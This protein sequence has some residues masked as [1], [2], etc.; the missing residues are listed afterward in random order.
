ML[1]RKVWLTLITLVLGLLAASYAYM[2]SSIRTISERLETESNQRLIDKA[3]GNLDAL[4]TALGSGSTAKVRLILKQLSQGERVACVTLLMGTKQVSYPEACDL[5]NSDATIAVSTKSGTTLKIDTSESLAQEL[6]RVLRNSF[7]L[8]FA[9]FIVTL[10]FF[11]LAFSYSFRYTG[12]FFL[13]T[14]ESLAQSRAQPTPSSF[15]FNFKSFE[16]LSAGVASRLQDYSQLLLSRAQEAAVVK[17]AAQVSHDI[18]SPLAVLNMLSARVKFENEEALELYTSSV[19]RIQTISNSLLGQPENFKSFVK[20]AAGSFMPS[21]E[22]KSQIDLRASLSKIINEKVVLFPEFSFVLACPEEILIHVQPTEWNRIL[23]NLLN[24]AVEAMKGLSGEIKVQAEMNQ[25][26]AV[27]IGIRDQGKGISS[28]MLAN[29]GSF[30]ESEGKASGTGLGLYHALQTI[31]SWGGA[32]RIESVQEGGTT[33]TVNL[34]AE[35]KVFHTAADLDF[36]GMQVVRIGDHQALPDSGGQKAYLSFSSLSEFI[37][38]YGKNFTEFDHAFFVFEAGLDLNEVLLS[39]RSLGIE[40]QSLVY[41]S[42]DGD[43]ETL[44]QFRTASIRVNQLIK[45]LTRN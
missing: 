35:V 30:A 2:N 28:S 12:K 21:F 5:K 34:A 20:K 13:Q 18:R 25:T 31:K 36:S 4:E 8:L 3:D 17:V 39:I 24:N 16:S 14:L 7:L 15:F 6:E 38:Y 44:D 42:S 9:G 43:P 19:D 32:L 29:I 41:A 33:V 26:N 10:G 45:N 37:S 23:S 27:S 40:E 1:S 22:P 11:I